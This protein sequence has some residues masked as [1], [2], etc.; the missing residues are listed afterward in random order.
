M[1]RIAVGTLGG[2][3]AMTANNLGQMQPTLTSDILIKNVPNLEKIADIHNH[4]LTQLPSGSLSF[5]ILLETIEWA[6]KQIKIGADGIVLTQGTDTL[7]ETA[8]FFPSIGIKL[9]RLS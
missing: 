9:N 8:F 3:I 6:T 2:T 7:E 5:K 4:T 1:K